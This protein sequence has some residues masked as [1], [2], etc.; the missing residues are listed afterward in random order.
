MENKILFL[1]EKEVD[2]LNGILT[3]YFVSYNEYNIQ[4]D[5]LCMLLM[6]L[7]KRAS[8]LV[9]LHNPAHFLETV[10]INFNDQN[11]I[12][13]TPEETLDLQNIFF[14][15]LDSDLFNHYK[16]GEEKLLIN[17]ILNFI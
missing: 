15:Y 2:L 10:I 9:N 7:T 5:H 11:E 8:P 13:L 4:N 1:N 12:E 17:K 16:N 14:S 6:Q 3:S